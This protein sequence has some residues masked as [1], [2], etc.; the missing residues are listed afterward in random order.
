MIDSETKLLCLL[1]NPVIHSKSPY[2]HNALIKKY[3]LNLVYLAFKV[4]DLEMIISSLKALN[5]LGANITLPYKS[6]ILKFLDVIDDDAK[7]C[8]AVNTILCKNK[9]LY[10]FNTDVY[11]IKK[12]LKVRDKKVLILG[13]GGAAKAACVAL[14]ANEIFVVNRNYERA[15]ELEKNFDCMAEPIKNLEV[16]VK[17]SDV[18]VNATPVGMFPNSDV[19]LI[20]KNFL[21]KSKIVFDMIYNPKET[22][23]LKDAKS[24]GA[25]TISGIEMFLHQGLKSFEIWTEIFPDTEFAK[26]VVL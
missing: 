9:K 20:P 8:R 12:A 21:K 14:K 26:R 18:V 11:G 24:V 2:L 23:L 4:F 25:K 17:K 6:E 22:K 13:A 7:A 10:G 15:C 16:V 3:N 5:F 1:G 19:S